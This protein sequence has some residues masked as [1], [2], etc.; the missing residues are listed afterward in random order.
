S[1]A[2]HLAG[3]HP[4]RIAEQ[5]GDTQPGRAG[6]ESP[7]LD[8][9]SGSW[10][11]SEVFRTAGRWSPRAR[12]TTAGVISPP[13]DMLSNIVCRAGRRAAYFPFSDGNLHRRTVPSLPP[14]RARWP[15]GERVRLCTP[16]LGATNRICPSPVL[17]SQSRT[18]PS[19]L[20]D[21]ARRA[22]GEMAT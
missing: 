17:K 6:G 7:H 2:G 14:K 22:S 11:R 5:H 20:Q 8:L 16:P 18:V 19:S 10:I 21:S 9:L 1:E 3:R 13:G 4:D 12:R 15:S